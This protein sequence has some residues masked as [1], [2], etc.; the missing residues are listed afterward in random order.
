MSSCKETTPPGVVGH[1]PQVGLANLF[2]QLRQVRPQEAF[3]EG[4]FDP[5]YQDVEKNSGGLFVR[6]LL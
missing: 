4:K 6:A 1:G 3:R 5:K 2:R